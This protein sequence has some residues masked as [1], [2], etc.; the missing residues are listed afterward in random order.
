M[1]TGPRGQREWKFYETVQHEKQAAAAASSTVGEPHV[2][3]ARKT[4][5]AK[6][7][8]CGKVRGIAMLSFGWDQGGPYIV[9]ICETLLHGLPRAIWQVLRIHNMGAHLTSSWR[10][11]AG[12]GDEN[13]NSSAPA[14]SRH[15]S[16]SNGVVSQQQSFSPGPFCVRNAV[17][18]AIIP[19]YCELPPGIKST[20][21]PQAKPYPCPLPVPPCMPHAPPPGTEERS[22]LR[23]AHIACMSARIEKD[24]QC[25]QERRR[26]EGEVH[27]GGE[28]L[29]MGA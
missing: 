5:C 7:W 19:Q 6:D 11:I 17:L 29:L 3:Q 28:A 14:A 26:A 1:Q 21:I 9:C 18:L 16:S 10:V 4:G 27:S 24:V 20:H 25:L 23:I 12:T 2:T 15:S 8:T 22:L 13:G